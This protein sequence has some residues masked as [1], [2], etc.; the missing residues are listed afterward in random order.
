MGTPKSREGT[1]LTISGI[2][3]VTLFLPSLPPLCDFFILVNHR[4]LVLFCFSGLV[5]I[6]FVILFLKVKCKTLSVTDFL[7]VVSVSFV[8]VNPFTS[9]Y[10]Y[11][12]GKKNYLTYS[13][14]YSS[15]SKYH[16]KFHKGSK[17][18]YKDQYR[19]RQKDFHRLV[20]RVS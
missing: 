12:N 7:L 20:T 1:S 2:V 3:E 8:F 19:V 11:N 15:V 4:I 17:I 18:K 9:I 13:Q 5:F 10:N 6:L 16:Q 14:T